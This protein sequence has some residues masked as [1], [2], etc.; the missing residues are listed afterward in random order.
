[1]G[2]DAEVYTVRA[3]VWEQ[4]GMEPMGGCLCIGYLE[5]RLGRRLRPKDFQRGDAFNRIPGTAR[6]LNRQKR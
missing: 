3:R 4:S 6:L 1:M 2:P 5:R